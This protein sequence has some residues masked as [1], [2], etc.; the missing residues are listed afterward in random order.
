MP[1]PIVAIDH[2][3]EYP[4]TNGIIFLSV[5]TAGDELNCY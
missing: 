3:T 1:N 4:P 5:G 2:Q